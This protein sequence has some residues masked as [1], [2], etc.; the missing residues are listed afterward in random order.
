MSLLRPKTEMVTAETALRGHQQ[1][2]YPVTGDPLRVWPADPRTVRARRPE[3]RGVRHGL[4]LGGG[5]DFW[6][7]P[8][9]WSTAVGYSGGFTPYPSYEQTCSGRTGHAGWSGAKLL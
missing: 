2:Q 6:E 1:Y 5:E 3:Q 7:R 4:L 8:Q 9:V